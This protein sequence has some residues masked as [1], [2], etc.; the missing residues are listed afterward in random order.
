M[1]RKRRNDVDY[2]PFFV[3][4]GRTLQILESKYKCKGTGFF[5]NVLRFLSGR[6]N[7]HFSI[8]DESDKLWFLT[9]TKCDEESAI[10]MLNTMAITGKINQKLWENKII[11]SEAFLE[12]IEDAYRKRT[13]DI[14]T[15][16]EIFNHYKITSAENTQGSVNPAEETGKD[17]RNGRQ[18][19]AIK[20][21]RKGKETK[22]K[23]K[24]VFIPPTEND[25]IDYFNTKGYREDVARKVFEY[26]DTAGWKDSTGKPVLNWKQKMIAVWF[27]DENKKVSQQSEKP[28]TKEELHRELSRNE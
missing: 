16:E 7:H 10:D 6:P 13:N 9:A 25:V 12:S 15:I 27:K 1:A 28:L 24:K 4:N 21:Q 19:S 17:N 14:V 26:Y 20:P 5:T 22:E 11:V 23:E 2:F 8:S 3:K 18:S